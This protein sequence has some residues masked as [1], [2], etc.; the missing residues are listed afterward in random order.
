[1]TSKPRGR[2]VRRQT[3]SLNTFYIIV[4]VVVLLGVAGLAALVLRP[5]P[6]APEG[7]LPAPEAVTVPTGKTEDGFNFKGNADA[8]VVV[9]EFADFQCPACG[10]FTN[11]L[12]A[13]FEKDYV[14]SGKIKFVYHDYPLR[15]HTNAVVAAEA[16]RCADDQGA[17]WKMHKMLFTNQRQWSALPDPKN[18]FATYATQLGIDPAKVT[19]CLS[20]ETNKAAVLAAQASG[21]KLAISG[22]PSF[23]INGT[24]IDTSKAQSVDEI[25]QIVRAAIDT[26]VAK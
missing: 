22:T 1:M 23:A 11:S 7:R 5:A 24:L 16:A 8:K 25:A 15:Q 13:Q 26:A 10:Y 4:G 3:R 2:T 21:D 6:A 19:S 20:G 14:A 9:T 18:Q 17:F 12:S